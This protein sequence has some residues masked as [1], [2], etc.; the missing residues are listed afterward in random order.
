[1]RGRLTPCR[2]RSPESGFTL[3]E[4]LIALALL[5]M[6]MVVLTGAMR[7]M[8]QTEARIG[9]RLDEADRYRTTVYFLRD[10]LAHVSLRIHDATLEGGSQRALFFHARPDALE[11]I[12]TMPA[13][14]G[15]GGRHYMRLA[16]ESLQDGSQG[17]VL[18]FSPWDGA[19]VFSDW[20]GAN[21]QVLVQPVSG[22]ALQYQHPVTGGWTD[23]WVPPV[24]P[25]E[26][27]DFVLPSAV[28]V[29]VQGLHPAW[30]MIQ[31]EL[32]PPFSTDP[33]ISYGATGG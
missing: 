2:T 33:S 17:L 14:Y 21:A 8:G 11:W 25:T 22:L 6:L 13:R 23:A 32:L 20:A 9:Q 26:T 27:L 15:L 24:N 1:M 28:A 12:G 30:P 18:R 5:S 16:V 4:V 3:V 10:V 19:S 31:T 29:H 7:T